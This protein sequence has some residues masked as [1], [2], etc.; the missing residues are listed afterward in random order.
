MIGGAAKRAA[1]TDTKASV[2][3]PEVSEARRAMEAV[4][5]VVAEAESTERALRNRVVARRKAHADAQA[6]EK[7]T[8]AAFDADESPELATKFAAAR[9]ATTNAADLIARGELQHKQATK[10]LATAR[11]ALA[12]RRAELR[13]LEVSRDLKPE[14]IQSEL[15]PS[16]QGFVDAV[17]A[18]RQHASNLAGVVARLV[19]LFADARSVGLPLRDPDAV[20]LVVAVVDALAA[21]G[22]R[23]AM[24]EDQLHQLRVSLHPGGPDIA[25]KFFGAIAVL[26]NILERPAPASVTSNWDER[27]ENLRGA[28][29]M[30][31]AVANGVARS[32]KNQT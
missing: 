1:T 5:R 30:G 23:L 16:A 13:R 21:R 10:S 17:L 12:R 24:N 4:E 3:T 18:L 32:R 15:A 7:T 27:L 29:T 28:L 22:V 9:A 25:A 8:G 11:E 6:A 19:P 26:C 31:E 14:A 2:D 20:P